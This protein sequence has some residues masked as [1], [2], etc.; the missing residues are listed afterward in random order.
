MSGES[1]TVR[2]V[3]M[4]EGAAMPALGLGTWEMGV[5]AAAKAAAA[6]RSARAASSSAKLLWLL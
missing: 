1:G 2:R 6:S 3:A 4:R 5:D